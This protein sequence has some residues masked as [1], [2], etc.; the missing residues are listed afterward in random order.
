MQ[1]DEAFAWAGMVGQGENSVC[2]GTE[3]DS[4]SSGPQ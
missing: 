1:E 2:Q 3:E 4:A